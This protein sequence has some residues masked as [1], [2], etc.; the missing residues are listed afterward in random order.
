MSNSYHADDDMLWA[1][2][3]VVV[4]VWNSELSFMYVEGAE[5]GN[6]YNFLRFCFVFLAFFFSPPCNLNSEIFLRDLRFMESDKNKISDV[7]SRW[8]MVKNLNYIGQAKVSNFYEWKPS[9]NFLY[10]C[11]SRKK[12][13]ISFWRFKLD[14]NKKYWFSH[15]QITH[16]QLSQMTRDRS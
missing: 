11:D 5:K 16:I 14:S 9:R 12:Q 13:K 4:C 2:I 8:L 15:T 1:F 10:F 7:S 3:V 6:F